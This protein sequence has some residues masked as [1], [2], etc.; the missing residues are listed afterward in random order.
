MSTVSDIRSSSV[1]SYQT[2]H[3]LYSNLFLNSIATQNSQKMNIYSNEKHS[4][5]K[6]KKKTRSKNREKVAPHN[7][8]RTNKKLVRRAQLKFNQKQTT[9]HQQ[10]TIAETNHVHSVVC[11]VRTLGIP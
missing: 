9:P 1:I 11:F 7:N 2:G 3:Y 10:L 5:W 6:K 8:G 4:P